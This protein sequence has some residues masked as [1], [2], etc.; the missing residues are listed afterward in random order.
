MTDE[1]II[2]VKGNSSAKALGAAISHAVYDGRHVTLRAIGAGAVNQAF[3][4][5]AIARSFTA[6]RGIDL[7]IRP[8]FDTVTMPDGASISAAIMVV[9]PSRA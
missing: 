3:K 2:R 9:I 8:G 7:L 4:A 6:A 5:T 1:E